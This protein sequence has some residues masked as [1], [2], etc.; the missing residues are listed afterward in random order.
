MEEAMPES[1]TH[2][3]VHF[4]WATWDRLPL[5]TPEL[6]PQVYASI[7]KK[8]QELRCE[9]RAIGGVENH[10][11][12][13][14]RLHATVSAAELAKGMKGASSHLA[15]HVLAPNQFFK[16]QGT[17]GAFSVSLE[18]VPHV[19][20]YIELQKE[21]HARSDIRPDWERCQEETDLPT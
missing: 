12:T 18:D 5:I 19:R 10:V 7:A 2:L 15:T 11:H 17:Y 20:A 3:Y 1:C 21:H 16:W 8:C 13:L 9:L 4:V 6:E 14:I